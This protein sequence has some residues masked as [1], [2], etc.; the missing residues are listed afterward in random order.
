MRIR[1]YMVVGVLSIVIF[2]WLVYFLISLIGSHSWLTQRGT[3]Q[4]NLTQTTER[5][6]QDERNWASADW[7]KLM[8]LQL[9]HEGVDVEI[10]SPSNQ[11][12]FESARQGF[13]RHQP[14][15]SEQRTAVMNNGQ[16]VGTVLVSQPG[17][18]DPLAAVG[19]ILA[20]VFAVTFVG[21]QMGRNVI[22]PL[23]SMNRAA[24]RI[25]EGDFDFTIAAS[26]AV[27]IRQVRTAFE[28]MVKGLREAFSKQQK[29][30]EERKFFIGA[31]AHDLRTPL[32]ALR[33]FLDGMEQGIAKSPDK[34]AHY[35]EVCQD[36]A[37][38]LDRL[39]SDLFAFTRLEYMEQ[40]LQTEAFNLSEVVN[41]AIESMAR[42]AREKE[43][44]LSTN[45]LDVDCVISGDPHLLERAITNLLDNA[46]RH[47]PNQGSVTIRL[48]RLP[49]KIELTMSDTGSGFDNDD[50]V[51]IFEPLYRG[52]GSRNASTGGAGLGLS[53]AR[54]I[55]RCHGGDLFAENASSGGA[56]LTGWMPLLEHHHE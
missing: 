3:G 40:T 21:L 1:K 34:L 39:V 55:F 47:T 15:M 50:L 30:E 10:R 27:E 42:R 44:V 9:Q 14:W 8:A 25:A 54:R 26:S 33:G 4:T 49:E 37:A 12:I 31:I 38:H 46:L 6:I 48:K 17:N 28:V 53:I 29:L 52:D 43:I 24:L 20:C 22:K 32:F 35:L 13:H 45:T 19:A 56:V 7:Q 18:A 23:E 5:M 16:L 41:T 2:P 51:R 36:K 11:V